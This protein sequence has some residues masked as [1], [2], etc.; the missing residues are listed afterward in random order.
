MTKNLLIAALLSIVVV[1]GIY[2]NSLREQ[3]ET[4]RAAKIE[5]IKVTDSLIQERRISRETIDKLYEQTVKEVEEAKA[6]AKVI[7]K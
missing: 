5:A 6:K 7:R 2:N 3:I 1:L 4:E